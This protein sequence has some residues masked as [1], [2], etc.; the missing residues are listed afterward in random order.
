MPTVD[1]S[2]EA[3][4]TC[5]SPQRPLLSGVQRKLRYWIGISATVVVP[6]AALP[7]EAERT[8]AEREKAAREGALRGSGRLADKAEHGT[9][10]CVT[11]PG[12]AEARRAQD[13]RKY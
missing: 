7:V 1:V 5:G 8:N 6:V 4:R 13:V 11:L 2:S 12:I 9:W 3:S 10:P